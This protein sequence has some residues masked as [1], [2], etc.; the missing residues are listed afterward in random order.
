[1]NFNVT[2]CNEKGNKLALR[3]LRQI[4]G[5]QYNL[6]AR[7]LTHPLCQLQMGHSRLRVPC[8]DDCA[9]QYNAPPRPRA[10]SGMILRFL[11]GHYA[12]SHKRATLADC[13]LNRPHLSSPHAQKPRLLRGQCHCLRPS[14]A[15][16]VRHSQLEQ[17]LARYQVIIHWNKTLH[18]ALQLPGALVCV[19]AVICTKPHHLVLF[20]STPCCTERV[21][22]HLA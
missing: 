6:G 9:R 13:Q 10:R 20:S 4:A 12:F 22:P 2:I 21:K 14:V 15:L 3:P 19:V 16:S 7:L 5:E 17:A 1:M 18:L 8:Q 11:R